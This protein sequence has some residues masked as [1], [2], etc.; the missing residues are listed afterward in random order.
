MKPSI[1]TI[2]LM[3]QTLLTPA[4]KEVSADE[5]LLATRGIIGLR[6]KS[7]GLALTDPFKSS[8]QFTVE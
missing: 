3:P 1:A 6:G 2:I 7:A 5:T 8:L 4:L